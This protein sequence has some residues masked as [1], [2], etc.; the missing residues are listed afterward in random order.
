[1]LIEPPQLAL[2][3]Q[4]TKQPQ[5]QLDHKPQVRN[6]TL[7]WRDGGKTM[8]KISSGT[9]AIIGGNEVYFMHWKHKI[10]SYNLTSKRWSK[11]PKCAVV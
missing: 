10:C 9:V 5:L 2:P 7:N 3:S 11:F 4:S 1:M 8:F 6:I